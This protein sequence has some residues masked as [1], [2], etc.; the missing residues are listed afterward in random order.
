MTDYYG[1]DPGGKSRGRVFSFSHGIVGQAFK[2]REPTWWCVA[3]GTALDDAM[4]ERWSFT[5]EERAR[6]TQ[7]RRSFFAYPVGQDGPYAQAVLFIDSARQDAFGSEA[8][9]DMVRTL[10]TVFRPLLVE[11]LRRA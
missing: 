11:A 10:D 8:A 3:A 4:R 5:T 6:I 1:H 2:N 9:D 7:D